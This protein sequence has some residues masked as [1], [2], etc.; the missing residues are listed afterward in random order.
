MLRTKNDNNVYDKSA[1]V[2]INDIVNIKPLK[3][4]EEYRIWKK[5][6]ET[7]DISLRNKLVTSNLKFV[8]KV[9]KEFRGRGLSY[10]DLIEEG[11][12]GL[13]RGIEKFD[14]S[15]NV[16]VISY[17]VWWI[18]QAIMEALEK[19]NQSDCEDL[20]YDYTSNDYY[21][22]EEESSCVST[23]YISD[24]KEGEEDPQKAHLKEL[25]ACLTPREADVISMY[26]GLNGETP[27]NLEDIGTEIGL[28]K[29][30]VRQISETAL[31]KMREKSLFV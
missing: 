14:G 3:K 28:T 19:R 4:S 9:A 21:E 20:P 8:M 30:R 1:E 11:N 13:I 25:M 17:S 2:Y 18:K 6:K 27:L 7:G 31:K 12:L 22:K 15:K 29:E 24:D 23:E 16:K 26:Y 5:Y 10:Q